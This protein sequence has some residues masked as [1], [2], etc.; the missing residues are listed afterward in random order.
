[1]FWVNSVLRGWWGTG[2]GCLEKLW[3]PGSIQGK[4]GWGLWAASSS[5]RCLLPWQRVGTSWSLR[6]KPFYYSVIPYIAPAHLITSF[7]KSIIKSVCSY[8]FSQRFLC[9]SFI[10]IPMMLILYSMQKHFKLPINIWRHRK[11]RSS[12]SFKKLGERAYFICWSLTSSRLDNSLPLKMN[13]DRTKTGKDKIQLWM[14]RMS[15]FFFFFFILLEIK[16]RVKG[17]MSESM[18]RFIAWMFPWCHCFQV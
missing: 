3:I 4:M 1:M 12:M 5:G 7:V 14:I 15:P 13:Q 17:S 6:P 16:L 9:W 18:F 2:S 10:W 11:Q 8:L